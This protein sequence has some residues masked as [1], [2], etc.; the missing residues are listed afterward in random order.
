MLE[1][2]R[3]EQRDSLWGRGIYPGALGLPLPRLELWGRPQEVIGAKENIM[4][5][6]SNTLKTHYVFSTWKLRLEH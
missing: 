3:L 6:E 1:I 5:I 2:G 4:V